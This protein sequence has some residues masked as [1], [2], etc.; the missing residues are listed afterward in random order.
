MKKPILAI[1]ALIL[2][3]LACTAHVAQAVP[4]DLPVSPTPDTGKTETATQEATVTAVASASIESE[5]IA[6]VQLPTVNVRKA[7]GGA[8]I[9]TLEAGD[10]VTILSCDGSWCKIEDPDGYIFRGCLSDN[11]KKLGCQAK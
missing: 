6:T 11:P 4:T 1:L 2:A 7:P 10:T 3:T 8:V 5:W 9:D